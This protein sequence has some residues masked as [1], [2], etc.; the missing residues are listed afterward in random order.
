MRQ[1]AS[2]PALL[3]GKAPPSLTSAAQAATSGALCFE[4]LVPPS[5]A[6]LGAAL[7]YTR[8]LYDHADLGAFPLD[9]AERHTGHLRSQR[10]FDQSR[11]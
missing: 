7:R 10:N 5:A 8:A 9:A 3:R 4:E 11:A 6:E 1:S 2:T